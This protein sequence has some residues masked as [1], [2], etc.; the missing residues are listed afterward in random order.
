MKFFDGKKEE[1]EEVGTPGRETAGDT[2]GSTTPVAGDETDQPAA[3][4]ADWPREWDTAS[5]AP[6][7]SV[8]F[9]DLPP[10]EVADYRS[11]GLI[12]ARRKR[13]D[14]KPAL[15][16]LI[17]LIL[18]AALITGIV[19]IWPSSRARVPDL[20][21]KTLPEALDAAR[22][23][24]FSPAVRAWEYSDK[25]SDGVVLFQKPAGRQIVGKGSGI[26]LTVSKGARPEAGTQPGQAASGT[27]QSSQGG[28]GTGPY[29]GK[30]IT[31]DPGHQGPQASE[32]WSDPGMTI[33][34]PRDNGTRG[35]SS[36][37]AEFLL[38]LD[39]G[40]KLKN[41]LEQDGVRV[42]MTR[43]TSDIDLTDIMR[44]EIANNADSDLCV[45]IHCGNSADP[46]KRGVE[47][48]CPASDQW[49]AS[50]Y[51]NSKKAALFIQPELAK[52]C[53]IDDMGVL[54]RRDVPGFNWSRVPVVETEVGFLSNSKDDVLLADDQFRWKAAW[55]LRNGILK[56]LVNP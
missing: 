28:A 18:L 21:G 19:W 55:G 24:G 54:A 39:I 11:P 53:G 2:E 1:E 25:S 48:I 30:T 22:G 45:R 15:G 56:Y 9:F 42:V 26:L 43:E 31:I 37:N 49:T 23:K 44:A 16:L 3:G 20:V 6:T 36:G 29:S 13:L 14:L 52:S 32:E 38:T 51:E 27:A 7:G 41:L 12:V 33:K 40:I 35:I 5:E 46:Y 50:F 10:D 34:V 17:F 4:K 47:T 8:D